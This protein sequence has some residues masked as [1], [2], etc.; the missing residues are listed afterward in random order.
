[1]TGGNSN[2]CKGNH[3]RYILVVGVGRVGVGLKF[4]SL[5]V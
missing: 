5:K 3:D 4:K 1:M 2:C